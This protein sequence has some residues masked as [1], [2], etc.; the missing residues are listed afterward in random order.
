MGKQFEDMC[1]DFF[2][3]LYYQYLVKSKGF[4]PN[5]NL[6]CLALIEM[7]WFLDNY[8]RIVESSDIV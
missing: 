7:I 5:Q 8:S 4:K 6:I 3:S 2:F 1:A